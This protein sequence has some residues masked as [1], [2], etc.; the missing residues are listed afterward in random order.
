MYIYFFIIFT[1]GTQ[2]YDSLIVYVAKIKGP[3]ARRGPIKHK[4]ESAHFGYFLLLHKRHNYNINRPMIHVT[5]LQYLFIYLYCSFYF[6]LLLIR[7]KNVF[8]LSIISIATTFTLTLLLCTRF[9]RV[10]I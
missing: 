10:D 4:C 7:R 6:Q 8:H 3:T 5:N 9:V 1:L 2:L